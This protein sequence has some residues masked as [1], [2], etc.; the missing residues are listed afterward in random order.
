VERR[1]KAIDRTVTRRKVAKLNLRLKRGPDRD[2]DA[3]QKILWLQSQ[4]KIVAEI[5]QS[6][7]E[8]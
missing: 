1:A 8:Q 2:A 7:D 5:L 3:E 4:I 6:L